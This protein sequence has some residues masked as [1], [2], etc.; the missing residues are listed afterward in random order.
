MSLIPKKYQ[1]QTVGE[2]NS[3]SDAA[4]AF[5]I[6]NKKKIKSSALK[7]GSFKGEKNVAIES[8]SR[9]NPRPVYQVSEESSHLSKSTQK[10]SLSLQK[11]V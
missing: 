6:E 7:F 3:D 4:P 10:S 5:P 8:N 9:K 1:L 11:S 2:T